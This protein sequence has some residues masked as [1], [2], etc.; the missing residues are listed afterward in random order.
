MSSIRRWLTLAIATA[1]AVA[2]SAAV[3]QVA[4]TMTVGGGPVPVTVPVMSTA[5]FTIAAAGEYQIDAMAEGADAQLFVVQD[6]GVLYEDSDSGDGADARVL[7]FLSPGTYGAR[8]WEYRGNPMNV[9][10]RVTRPPAFTSVATIAPSAPPAVV[11]VVAADSPRASSAELTLT[12][13]SAGTYRID[14]ISPDTS[15]DP[16]LLLIRDGAQIATDSDS[17]EGSNAQL[18]Q[19]LT[20][21][22]Y[23]LRVR[24]WVARSGAI[25]IT[26]VPQ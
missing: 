19:A 24:D 6:D 21:G 22:D 26:V 4:P 16:E 18:V 10:I 5:P 15:V 3:A 25:H 8:V 14:A 23:T 11:N 1:L 20:P 7:A 9:R 17:G 2:T 12:I 13:A